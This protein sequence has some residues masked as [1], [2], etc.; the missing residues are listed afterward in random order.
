MRKTVLLLAV[1]LGF[2]SAAPAQTMAWA[3][4]LFDNNTVKDFGVVPHGAQ[5]TYSFP[6]KNIYAVPL[7]ITNIRATCTCLTVTPSTNVL[8]PQ[9]TGYIKIQMDGRRFTGPKAITV[10][11]TVGPEYIS[12]ATLRVSA[13]A[14]TDVVLN[15]GQI[16]FGTVQSGA[17]ATQTVD[18]DYAGNLDWHISEVV[19]PTNSPFEIKLSEAYRQ[20]AK[21]RKAGKVGYRLSVTLKPDAPDGPF[22]HEIGLKTNDQNQILTITAEG[23]VQAA[24]TASPSRID[25]VSVKVGQMLTRKVFVRGSRPFQILAVDGVSDGVTVQFDANRSSATHFLTVQCQPQR[26]GA[27]QKQL[28]IRTDLEKASTTIF[29]DVNVTP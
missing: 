5:L 4:K 7:E 27:L 3:D 11:V 29:L 18:I 20:S 19:N 6:M 10:Y 2:A 24:L 21:L 25:G 16:N 12:T 26:A 1:W 15:P 17:G 9:E 8:K 14:R 28:V 23:T 22:R 13:N